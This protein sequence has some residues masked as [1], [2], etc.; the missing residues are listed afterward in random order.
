MEY[1]VEQIKDLYCKFTCPV[2]NRKSEN[3]CKHCDIA[4]ICDKLEIG[5]ASK[6]EQNACEICQIDNF[7]RELRDQKI[8]NL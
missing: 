3:D 6:E 1:S 5:C 2:K 7:I 4:N 8:I